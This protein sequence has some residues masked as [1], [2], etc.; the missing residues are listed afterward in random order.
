MLL[1]FPIRFCLQ[2]GFLI[3]R[4][5]PVRLHAQRHDAYAETSFIHP[6]HAYQRQHRKGRNV[7][8]SVVCLSGHHSSM[9][10]IRPERICCTD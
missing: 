5:L 8:H 4:F 1:H 3:I 7:R 9:A 10:R 2:D 6:I